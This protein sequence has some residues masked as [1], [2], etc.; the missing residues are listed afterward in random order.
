MAEL[1]DFLRQLLSAGAVAFPGH[2]DS[3][4]AGQR[5]AVDFLR[6]AFG[7]YRLEV[8]GPLLDFRADIALQAAEFVRQGCWFLVQHDEPDGAVEQRLTMPLPQTAADHLSADLLFRYLPGVYRRAR[9]LDPADVLVKRLEEVLRQWPL[10]GVLA[11]VPDAPST[12][13]DF[14]GHRGL[15]LLYAERLARNPK[16][17]WQPAGQASEYAELAVHELG[18]EHLLKATIATGAAA[19]GKVEQ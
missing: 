9:A 6:K 15:Q 17:E 12:A 7:Y 10:S 11:D 5:A 1:V 3:S 18:R 8:S 14:E 16:V 4:S 19:R 13:F 2:P